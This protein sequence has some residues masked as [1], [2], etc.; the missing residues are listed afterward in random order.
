[1]GYRYAIAPQPG[2]YVTPVRDEGLP[3]QRCVVQRVEA[4]QPDN[5]AWSVVLGFELDD[6]GRGSHVTATG[7][8]ALRWREVEL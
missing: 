3:G 5:N 2:D 1:M 7:E 8:R 4:Y 6:I